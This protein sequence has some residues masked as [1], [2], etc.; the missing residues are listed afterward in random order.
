MILTSF[1]AGVA[2]GV[3]AGLAIAAF[4]IL[5]YLSETYSE[6]TKK[7]DEHSYLEWGDTF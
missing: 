5:F 2:F 1:G 3:I 7:E 4:I 6:V